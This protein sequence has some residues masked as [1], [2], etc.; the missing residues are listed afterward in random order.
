MRRGL[1]RLSSALHPSQFHNFIMR[2]KSKVSVLEKGKMREI[3]RDEGL[4]CDGVSKEYA[5]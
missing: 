4:R 2:R 5:S 3:I 1:E